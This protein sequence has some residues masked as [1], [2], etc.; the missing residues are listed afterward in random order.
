ML[1]WWFAARGLGP[2]TQRIEQTPVEVH[3]VPWLVTK[4]TNGAGEVIPLKETATP[5]NSGPEVRP[6]RPGALSLSNEETGNQFAK[7]GANI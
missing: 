4:P 7:L 5:E 1:G 2:E 3:P 6:W